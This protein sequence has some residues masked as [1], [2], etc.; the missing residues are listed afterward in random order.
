MNSAGDINAV[1]QLASSAHAKGLDRECEQQSRK[2]LTL[3]P[4]HPNAMYLLGI[5][6]V[7]L[8]ELPESIKVLTDL[9]LSPSVVG[10]P[11]SNP[12][13]RSVE[14]YLSSA[15]LR[16]GQ[17]DLAVVHAER[18]AAF[19]KNDPETLFNLG[20]CLT[21]VGRT[22]EAEEKFNK[23]IQL[24]PQMPFGYSGLGSCYKRKGK[25]REAIEQI[26]KAASLTPPNSPALIDLAES[27]MALE[28]PKGAEEI[29]RRAYNA[30]PSFRACMVLAPCLGELGRAAEANDFAEEA[31]AADPESGPAWAVLGTTQQALGKRAESIESLIRS[32][33]LYPNQGSSWHALVQAGVL[34]P[35]LGNK[36]EDA[37]SSGA[38]S[39][40]DLS[41]LNYARGQYWEKVG[42]H[43]LSAEA[44]LDAN[45]LAWNQKY[46]E[47]K[48]DT[49]GYAAKTFEAV[50]LPQD[51][52][53][54]RPRGVPTEDPQPIFVVGMIRSGTTLVQ[55]ILSCHP[56]IGPGGEQTFWPEY[57]RTMFNKRGELD[58]S[59]LQALRS[60]YLRGLKKLAPGKRYVVDKMPEN[61]RLLGV[62]ALVFPDSPII[63]T[64]R[65]SRDTC[66]SIYATAN[67]SRLPFMHDLDAITFAYIQYRK[68]MNRWREVLPERVLDMQYEDL[69]S[70]Q[71]RF[72]REMLE[73]CGIEWDDACL[74]PEKNRHQAATP[75]GV[76]V[77][78]PVYTSSIG[79]AAHYEPWFGKHWSA[80]DALD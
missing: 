55:Q 26:L 7:K 24:A 57:W 38:M 47:V 42:K 66:L 51:W 69:V 75:S 18:A 15:L 44:Y 58:K 21:E 39:D 22:V 9:S 72:T 19:R 70:S 13:L 36:M 43:D 8:N 14:L 79:R 1:L 71:D 52:K 29:A 17:P 23:V 12:F 33:E 6:L 5:S 4:G 59:Q 32:T 54:I 68:I 31:V 53:A 64:A 61:Y 25:R 78:Q 20:L 16:N 56:E 27:L 28:Y 46:G 48:F 30:S 62:L 11:D 73:Y 40:Q 45:R 60:Q 34:N 65:D 76:Q 63:H 67:R 41:L 37:R 2:A 49:A 80:L 50:N 3:Q 74:K 35:E 77:Q 10:R